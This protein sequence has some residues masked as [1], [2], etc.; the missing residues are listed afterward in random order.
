MTGSNGELNGDFKTRFGAWLFSQG[1]STVLLCFILFAIGY[2]ALKGIPALMERQSQELK[3]CRDDFREALNGQ[4][5]SFNKAIER[6]C[7]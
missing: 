4:Q 6:C 7:K 2:A 3:Q 5:E 1:A